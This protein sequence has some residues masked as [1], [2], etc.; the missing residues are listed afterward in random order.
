MRDYTKLNVMA[1]IRRIG[2]LTSGGDCPGLNAAIRGVAKP[3][4]ERG[5]QIFGIQDGFRGLVENRVMELGP[6]ETSGLLVEGGTILGTSRYKPHKYPNRQGGKEDRTRDAVENYER[7]HLDALVCIGGGGT[8]KNAYHLLQNG[9]PNIVTLPK[10][11]DN[12]VYGTDVTFGYD[13]GMSIACEAIDR[14]HT[15]A[16]SHHRCMLVDVMGHNTGWLAMGAGIAG[17]ADVILIPEFP[18]STDRVV[19]A[20]IERERRS[21]RF[22]IVVVAEGALSQEEAELRK[23]MEKKEFKARDRVY[24]DNLSHDLAHIIEERVG[25]ETRITTLGH[26]QRGGIPTARDRILASRLGTLGAELILQGEF[27][28]MAAV[29]CNQFVPVALESM[30]GKKKYITADNGLVRTAGQLGVS[31]GRPR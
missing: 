17:G 2:I 1:D 28:V 15:T 18:F 8:H 26:L 22:S 7:L 20:L 16:S 31:L 29:N 25:I 27:G 14:L 19:E 24:S 11:I 10:T 4:L 30:V 6:R 12:D 21:K 3:L 13:T 9:I 23:G 5:V